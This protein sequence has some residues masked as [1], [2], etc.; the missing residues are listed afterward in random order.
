MATG[1]DPVSIFVYGTLKPGEANYDRYCKGRVIS[2]TPAIAPG[3]LY[4]LPAGYPAVVAIDRV[5]ELRAEHMTLPL[6][7]MVQGYRLQFRDS[8]C[9]RLLD[10]LED[11]SPKRSP[12]ENEYYRCSTLLFTPNHQALGKAWIYLMEPRRVRGM[13]GRLVQGPWTGRSAYF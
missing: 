1:M 10:E 5:S 4:A 7:P 8:G 6:K 9:L 2:E 3:Y 11:Y 13:A 12:H